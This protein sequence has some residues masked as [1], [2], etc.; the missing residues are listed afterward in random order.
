MRR[1]KVLGILRPGKTTTDIDSIG[2]MSLPIKSAYIMKYRLKVDTAFMTDAILGGL[3]RYPFAESRTLAPKVQR[4]FEVYRGEKFDILHFHLFN[5]SYIPSILSAITPDDKVVLTLHLPPTCG[6]SYYQ[7]QDQVAALGAMNNVRLIGVSDTGV[8]DY[9]RKSNVPIRTVHNGVSVN[10]DLYLPISEKSNYAT[11]IGRMEISKNILAG[12]NYCISRNIPVHYIG[13]RPQVQSEDSQNYAE[14]CLRVIHSH[15]DL[16]THHEKLPNREVYQ[17]LRR[18]QFNLS[19][20]TL[21]SFGMS[22]VESCMVGTPNMYLEIPGVQDTMVPGLTG[23]PIDKDR[24]YRKQWIKRY[25]VMD[26]A[27]SKIQDMT[28]EDSECMKNHAKKYFSLDKCAN[29]YVSVYGDLLSL[30]GG[31]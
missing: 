14:E 7:V 3:D 22:L 20:S 27:L 17:I 30:R 25:E 1:I 15:P 4:A 6:R 29:D 24:I 21:E 10:E 26:D 19:L 9:I 12:L 18:A 2:A 11:I 28:D 5:Y 31:Y 13:T 16:I 8:S 23:Y